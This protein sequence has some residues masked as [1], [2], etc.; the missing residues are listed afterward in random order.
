[1][2]NHRPMRILSILLL[3]GLTITV[4]FTAYSFY[5]YRTPSVSQE[6]TIFIEPGTGGRAIL[7][8]LHE[9]ALIPEP[10][11]ILLPIGLR[12]DYKSFKAGEYRF[13][14]GLTPSQIFTSIARGAVV[15]HAVTVPEGFT[16]A[17]VRALLLKEPL[18]SGELPASIPE[19]SLAADTMHF[20]RGD[21]RISLITRMQKEQTERLTS[22][23]QQRAD[24]LP[25]ATPQ[26]ALTM[27]SIVEEETGVPAERARVAAVYLSRLR[28]GMLLQADPTVAYGIAPGGMTRALTR[29]DLMRNSPYNTYL[30][31]GLPPGP[32]CNP[33]KAS[34]DAVMHPAQT[35]E[36]YF[37]ATGTGG[38]YFARTVQEHEQNV[39]RYRQ[40]QKAL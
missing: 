14:Q 26:D 31:A 13:A 12:G 35:D 36:L 18:L 4:G 28:R 25:L 7:K 5:Q 16:V 27:A 34:I 32:I 24:D 19:G 22:A 38:H 6:T 23:W 39:R 3:L 30:H 15:I 17:Q 1:M 2:R 8:Q 33:G 9:A 11:K 37:V 21:T 20:Q 10:W 40:A 29:R